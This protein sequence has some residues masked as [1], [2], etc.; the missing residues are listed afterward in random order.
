MRRELRAGIRAHQLNSSER[1]VQT[2]MEQREVCVLLWAGL[3]ATRGNITV[4][5]IP[6]RLNCCLIP[7]RTELINSAAVRIMQHGELRVG[8]PW[9]IG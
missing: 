9:F 1:V 3:R 6:I 2:D 7:I 5:A 8:D 4:S